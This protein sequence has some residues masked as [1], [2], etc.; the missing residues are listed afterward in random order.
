MKVLEFVN[1]NN[2][3]PIGGPNGYVYNIIN[4]L[5]SN[6]VIIETLPAYEE[7]FNFK[8]IIPNLFL[9][10]LRIFKERKKLKDLKKG[11]HHIENISSFDIIHFHSATDLMMCSNDLK[12]FN[13][14]VVLTIHSPIPPHIE[15]YQDFYSKIMRFF[16]GKKRMKLYKRIIE[17]AFNLTDYIVYPCEEAEESYYEL[18]EGYA[19]LKKMNLEKFIYLPTGCVEK[20][21]SI[22]KENIRK[23]LGLSDDFLI[24]YAGRHNTSK[25]Y[26]LL[27]DIVKSVSE[28]IDFKVVVCGKE[29]PLFSP[30][31][32]NWYEVGWTN[33]AESYI[34]SSDVFVLPNRWTYFDL[35]FL[36][37]L[38]LG[39]II[40]ASN[41]GGNKFFSKFNDCGIFLYNS[42]EEAEKYIRYVVN[43]SKEKKEEYEMKNK[44]LFIRFFNAN[45]FS[46]RYCELY[47]D[48]LNKVPKKVYFY[49]NI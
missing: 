13:G 35:V 34:F 39:K 15:I 6:D 32:K 28:K 7:T 49:D 24:S 41:T 11:L 38:S 33:N 19:E 1:K 17:E 20:N 45:N 27:I 36:E 18:W 22:S 21:P 16:G 37:V 12:S 31:L 44:Q 4:N 9:D 42:L 2:V 5:G 26:D 23:E 47:K 14:K 46:R 43:L 40:V 30:K 29:G 25:G 10:L 3:K 48:I 8:K